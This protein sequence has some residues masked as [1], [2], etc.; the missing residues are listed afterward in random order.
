M[1]KVNIEDIR[2]AVTGLCVFLGYIFINMFG[3]TLLYSLTGINVTLLSDLGKIIYLAVVNILMMAAL[4]F[5]FKKELISSFNDLKKNHKQYFSK[6]LSLWVVL[7]G[8]IVLS[9]IIITL[10]T[11]SE[12]SNNQESLNRVFEIAP[13]Y[14][15]FSAVIAA[16]FVE[17]LVFRQGFKYIYKTDWLYILV[18]GLAFGALHVIG[19]IETLAD[20]LYLIPYSIPG[21]GF[22]YMMAKTKNIFVSMG[23]HLLHNGLA[24]TLMFILL[25]FG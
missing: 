6:Y 8:L 18:S 10:T 2:K 22:A 14:F 5:I 17:E 3:T 24:A 11:G 9:N 19:N 12:I 23:F 1:N 15:F 20:V 21:W 4:Y 25:L 16:P 13:I 7:F